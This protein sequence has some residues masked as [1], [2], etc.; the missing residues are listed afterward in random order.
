MAP[1]YQYNLHSYNITA[2]RPLTDKHLHTLGA[3]FGDSRE[4]G[5]EALQG[6]KPLTCIELENIGPAVVKHYRRG[7]LI[8]WVNRGSYLKLGK[9]RPQ[10]EFEFLE[11]VGRLG[12]A[13]PE[14]LAWVTK[15]GYC[16]RGWLAMRHIDHMGNLVDVCRENPSR[17]K[18]AMAEMSSQIE[19]L[20]RHKVFH[21]DLHP[22]NIILTKDGKIYI[23]DWDKGRFYRGT[24]QQLKARLGSRWQRAVEKYGLPEF[25]LHM[26]DT[27]LAA[28][29]VQG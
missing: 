15:G 3:A 13:A 26:M 6:R 12:I 28:D 22:G 8:R 14:P 18:A 5:Y 20:L 11:T 9:T 25:L 10:R 17:A 7:G 16:Y 19:L 4:S 27:A 2:N 23:T 24:R 1:I 29:G 21:V